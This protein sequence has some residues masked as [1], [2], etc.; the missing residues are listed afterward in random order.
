MKYLNQLWHKTNKFISGYPSQ[1]NEIIVSKSYLPI[2]L[3]H[4]D[5]SIIHNSQDQ[6]IETT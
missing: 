2:L 5:C 3:P 4:V 6:D 1:G